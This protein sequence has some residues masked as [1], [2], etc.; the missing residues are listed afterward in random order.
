MD[1][2]QPVHDY[3]EG[4]YTRVNYNLCTTE[5]DMN[6]HVPYIYITSLRDISRIQANIHLPSLD[7]YFSP[8]YLPTEL[9]RLTINSIQSKANTT[10]EQSI[11]YFTRI[12]LE[13]LSIFEST[14]TR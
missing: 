12:N 14:G 9:I 5:Y 4:L 1:K 3:Y 10:E 13:R 7:I 11:G 8:E 2:V 6:L